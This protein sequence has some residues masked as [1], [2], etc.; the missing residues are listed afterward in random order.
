MLCSYLQERTERG[1]GE[2]GEGSQE[3][4]EVGYSKFISIFL[5]GGREGGQIGEELLGDLLET[6]VNYRK[7]LVNKEKGGGG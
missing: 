2:R 7:D 5:R 3:I 6:L 4:G 1:Y